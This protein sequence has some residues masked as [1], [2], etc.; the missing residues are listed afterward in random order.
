MRA[1]KPSRTAQ[2]VAFNRALGTLAPQVP[3]FSDPTAVEFLPTKWRQK[4]EKTRRAI[5]RKPGK[6][7]LPSWFRGMGIFNQFRT[8][9]LDLAIAQALAIGQLVI[10]G[11]GL[12]SCAWR[13]DRL[14]DSMLFEV[15]HPAT[16][17]WKRSANAVT[18]VG[19][20]ARFLPDAAVKRHRI[21]FDND[22][23]CGAVYVGLRAAR[24]RGCGI[25]RDDCSHS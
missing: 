16:Q 4:V 25:S 20:G 19:Q 8:V 14:K 15:D 22:A 23:D 13:L 6:P 5:T 18:S 9:V 2:F 7:P 24:A 10:L 12:D 3:G 21:V 11:A 1:G 17:A